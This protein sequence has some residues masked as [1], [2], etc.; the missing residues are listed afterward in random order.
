MKDGSLTKVPG[1]NNV[2]FDLSTE[3]GQRELSEALYEI[4]SSDFK[5]RISRPTGN[6]LYSLVDYLHNK[7]VV[8]T[9]T[10]LPNGREHS[11]DLDLMVQHAVDAVG[12]QRDAAALTAR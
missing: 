1:D 4:T 12:A 11:Y 7:F 10:F 3:Q 9:T 8:P 2:V 5:A 6:D